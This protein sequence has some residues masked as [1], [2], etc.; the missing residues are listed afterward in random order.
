MGRRVRWIALVCG[1]IGGA[2]GAT[3]TAAESTPIA[4]QNPEAV[5]QIEQV[6]VTARRRDESL[7]DVPVA[8]TSI[9]GETLMAAGAQDLTALTQV[10]PNITLEPARGTNTTLAAFI[11]GVGQQDPVA[12][13]EQGVGIYLDDVY[14]NRPQGAVLDLYDVERVEVLRGPQGTLYGRNTIGGAVKYVTRRLERDKPTFRARVAYGSYDQFD[15]LLSA[16][17]P[18]TESFRLGA[19]VASFQRDGFGK[20]RATGEEHYDKDVVAARVSAEWEP[21]DSFQAR[22]SLDAVEDES[23]PRHGYRLLPTLTSGQQH[24]LGNKFDTTAGVSRGAP[25]SGNTSEATGGQL[26]LQWAPAGNWTIRSISAFREDET[27]TMIDFDSSPSPSLDG[28]AVYKNEQLSQELQV[29]FETERLSFVGGLY[30]LDANAFNAYDVVFTSVTSLTLGDVDTQ[31]WAAFG[32]ATYDLTDQVNLSLGLRYTE[33]ERTSHVQRQ[34]Y[35]GVY[36]PYFGNTTAV[37]ITSTIVVDGEEV[38]PNFHGRRKD[39]AVTPRVILAW[40]PN[41]SVNTYISYSEGFKG[42]GFDPRGN[43]ANADVRR[44]FLPEKVDSYELGLK[45]SLLDGSVRMNSAIFYAEYTD[46]QIPG[47]V[48]IPGPPV[49]FVG[50]VTN[51]GAAEMKGVEIESWVQFSQRLS[52]TVSLGYIDADYTEFIVGG[53]DVSAQRDVQNTPDWSGSASLTWAAPLS[54]GHLPGS[55]SVS[56]LAAYRGK[57]QQ[58]EIEI[59]LIDQPAYWLY[60]ASITWISDSDRWRFGLHG[61]NLT[62]K[63]YMTSGFNF[64]GPASDDSVTALYGNPRTVTASVEVRF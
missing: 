16:S 14:L 22:L 7:Q 30:Y 10:A 6:V 2:A 62:D 44:G 43:F 40:K 60:D 35:I 48:V 56:A 57:T 32:E 5:S 37:G 21:S 45:T 26:T 20:N 11:R 24:L 4:E 25:I 12:G 61:R 46:V 27:W 49:S 18:L 19:A 52:G 47:T 42:G 23:S 50:T 33:D 38:V 36:S 55:V 64:P 9:S 15:A 8:V 39:S 17:A 28:V 63:R 31:T 54:F 1:G 13:F 59:P 53:L 34:N 3:A 51:A 41:D 58:Y 29:N